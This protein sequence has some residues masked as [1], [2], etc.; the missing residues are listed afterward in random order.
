MGHQNIQYSGPMIDMEMDQPGQG[1]FSPYGSISNF[2]QPNVILAA[3]GT[4]NNFD[5]HHRPDHIGS[6]RMP[7]YNVVQHQYPSGSID[8]SASAASNHYNM[9]MAPS[10]SARGF[11][12]PLNT[13]AYDQFLSS[14]NRGIDFSADSYGRNAQFI[15]ELGGSFKRK[16]AEVFPRNFQHYASAGSSSSAAPV[17]A[18][19]VESDVGPREASFA[20]TDSGGI[21]MSSV[22][23]TGSHR[24]MR[25]RPGV[26]SVESLV[27]HNPSHL[28]RGQYPGQAFQT[29]SAPWMDQQFNGDLTWNQT[30]VLP[31]LHGNFNGLCMEAANMGVHAY[32]VTANRASATFLLPPTILPGHFNLHH[33]SPPLPPVQGAQGRSLELHPQVATSSRRPS[34]SGTSQP[35][36]NTIQDSGDMSSR[37]VGSIYPAGLR[38]YRP[39]RRE[40]VLD[41]SA[42]QRNLHHLRVLPEDGVALLELSDYHGLVDSFDHHREMRLDI[43]NMSYEEL[44]ALGEQIGS[45]ASGLSEEFIL[46]RLKS[47]IFSVSRSS[48]NVEDTASVDQ[49]LN[50]C[51]VCQAEYRDEEKKGIL[52]CGHEYHLECIKKW[53]L[54]KNTCPICK[55][56]AL[57]TENKEE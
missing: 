15:D 54:V 21:D 8:L 10:S 13:G 24:S 9:Y 46:G 49:E 23:D 37:F 19:P 2:P 48:S 55:S 28:I 51:V 40:L 25:N 52:D 26:V 12:L 42:R 50:F 44:L 53:L 33:P 27:P 3:P 38:I 34:T 35:S 31:Y 29:A 7:Q 57:T 22:M 45:V 36:I 39:Q 5:V 43:D 18:R 56:A 6:Y 11:P 41:A 1:H 30:H 4:R 17:I 20:V 14:S 32:P 16:N 47:R